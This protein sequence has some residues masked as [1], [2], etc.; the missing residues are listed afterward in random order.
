MMNAEKFIGATQADQGRSG[1][2]IPSSFVIRASSLIIA[3]AKKTT[4]TTFSH[5]HWT[6]LRL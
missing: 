1:F 6:K 3:L 2:V 5:S 4:S